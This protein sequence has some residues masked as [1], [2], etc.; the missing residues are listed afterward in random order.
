MATERIGIFGDMHGNAV[1]FDAVQAALQAEGVERFVCLGD[2]VAI[3]PQPREVLRRLRELNCPVVM[4]N[5]DAYVL[6]PP[7]AAGA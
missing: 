3:G 5:T 2:V 1:A 4:G 6:E 7:P